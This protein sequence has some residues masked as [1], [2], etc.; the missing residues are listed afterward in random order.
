MSLGDVIV[1]VEDLG[2]WTIRQPDAF[3]TFVGIFTETGLTLIP[4]PRKLSCTGL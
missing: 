4:I 3:G 1:Y 2:A